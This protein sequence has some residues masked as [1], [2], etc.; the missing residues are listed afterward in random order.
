MS[1]DPD[2]FERV[3]FLRIL[4]TRREG[5]PV[6]ANTVRADAD[7]AQIRK[8]VIG[9]LCATA[10]RQGLLTHEGWVRSDQPSAKSRW[11]M[12]Y[13]RTDKDVP[14]DLLSMSEPEGASA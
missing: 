1:G 10:V 13:R 5:A 9:A 4:A 6:N 14:L 3:V 2:L 11:V 8:G 7:A 12:T